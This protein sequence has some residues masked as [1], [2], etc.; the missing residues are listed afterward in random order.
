MGTHCFAVPDH[1]RK[2]RTSRIGGSQKEIFGS[3]ESI[4][5]RVVLGVLLCLVAYAVAD[6]CDC[7]CRYK[8]CKKHAH[9]QHEFARCDEGLAICKN[10][11]VKIC[12]AELETCSKDAHTPAQQ[13]ACLK[14]WYKCGRC[15]C[16]FDRCNK[17]AEHYHEVNRCK[18]SLDVCR[19]CDTRECDAAAEICD[20][21]AKTHEELHKC[22]NAWH[23]CG[24]CMCRYKECVKHSDPLD[25]EK[26]LVLCKTCETKPCDTVLDACM[27][28]VK[29]HEELHVCL[30][31]WYACVQ[32]DC[33]V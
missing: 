14:A 23:K 9:E 1:G 4:T 2:S 6:D 27:L 13:A 15:Y 8:I 11:P 24:Q 21:R 12:N 26:G 25:C 10:C 31:A 32:K 22:I 3:E 33:K 20:A 29:T 7:E 30:N 28:K 16:K 19:E 18:L 17:H 5:M